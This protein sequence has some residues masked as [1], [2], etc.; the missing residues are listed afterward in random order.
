MLILKNLKGENQTPE[1]WVEGLRMEDR[2]ELMTA[3]FNKVGRI[4]L[5]Q[6]ESVFSKLEKKDA[7]KFLSNIARGAEMGK[8]AAIE[9]EIDNALQTELDRRKGVKNDN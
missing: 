5:E 2:A 9:N 1:M 3:L 4:T 8:N 7:V 6:A